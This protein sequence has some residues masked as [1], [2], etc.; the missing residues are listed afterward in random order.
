MPSAQGGERRPQGHGVSESECTRGRGLPGIA[1]LR[2][3][4]AG[5]PCLAEERGTA[6]GGAQGWPGWLVW[7]VWGWSVPGRF[8]SHKWIPPRGL[9]GW[10]FSQWALGPSA[11]LRG[12]SPGPGIQATPSLHLPGLRLP[13]SH[14][15]MGPWGRAYLAVRTSPLVSFP[16]WRHTQE[17][18]RQGLGTDSCPW[19]QAF[20]ARGHPASTPT[21][22]PSE[23]GGLWG[24]LPSRGPGVWPAG[25][26]AQSLSLPT[27]LAVNG[28][29]WCH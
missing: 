27:G 2:S 20:P 12:H 28:C 19:R 14:S 29:H 21:T 11:H 18:Q 16:G 23:G 7:S 26:Q 13:P 10:H 4:R 24:L 3:P 6:R 8:G 22:G 15:G 9:Y 1:M 25:T 17:G 5:G